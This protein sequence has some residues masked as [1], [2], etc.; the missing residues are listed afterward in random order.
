MERFSDLSWEDKYQMSQTLLTAKNKKI[1]K[2]EV[3]IGMLKSEKSELEDTSKAN[4][5]KIAFL[6][7][8]LKHYK[9]LE[10]AGQLTK[11]YAQQVKKEALYQEQRSIVERKNEEIKRLE[12][13]IEGLLQQLRDVDKMQI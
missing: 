4:D 3:E 12:L 13:Q 8:K 9:A 10:Q 6:T 7:A 2:L 1:S 5:I 11:E